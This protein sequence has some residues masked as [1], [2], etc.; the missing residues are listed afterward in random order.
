[1]NGKAFSAVHNSRES[2]NKTIKMDMDW[3]TLLE[4]QQADFI[5]RLKSG[6]L[7]HSGS[8][9]QHSELTVISG[10][11]LDQLRDFCWEMAEKYK[12]NK[13]VRQLF[14]NNM[15]GKLGEEVVKA[16]LGNF[17]T[18]V[19]YEKKIGGDGK[20]DFTLKSNSYI[21]IQVKARQ[22]NINTLRWSIDAEEIDKN[23]VLVCILIQEEV[24]EAQAE[25]HLVLGG[26]LPTNIIQPRLNG[27][28]SIS[29]KIED[30]FY[31]G[32]LRC[33]LEEYLEDCQNTDKE[34]DA[35]LEKARRA[36][37]FSEK[38]LGDTTK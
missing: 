31:G 29:F 28:N 19:D 33:Y 2:D 16:R 6:H 22:G 32:G 21:G 4:S 27:N 35:L 24:S 3:T 1:M 20:V 12:R 30:L 8:E 37:E 14:I 18:E 38:I 11:R 25:Y 17:V 26:F 23:T 9:G 10:D 13:P 34:F 15:K 7:L 36:I 5:E